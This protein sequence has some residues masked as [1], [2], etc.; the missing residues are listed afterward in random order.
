M[1]I[2]PTKL[3]PR[4]A[5][6]PW[7]PTPPGAKSRLTTVTDEPT[8]HKPQKKGKNMAGPRRHGPGQPTHPSAEIPD[9]PPNPEPS[10]NPT[11]HNLCCLPPKKEDKKTARPQHL[12]N[13]DL[14]R[15]K[16]LTLRIK[17]GHALHESE[18]GTDNNTYTARINEW[19]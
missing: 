9:P 19:P 12:D 10:K 14:V 16:G 7:S 6:E 15:E 1:K 5:P 17:P 2:R 11:Q 4:N 13:P 3:H 8:H 18:Q